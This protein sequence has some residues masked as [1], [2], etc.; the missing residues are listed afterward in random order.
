MN[1]EENKEASGPGRFL[2]MPTM[3]LTIEIVGYASS[4]VTLPDDVAAW[5]IEVSDMAHTVPAALCAS[6]VGDV[7]CDD[8]LAHEGDPVVLQ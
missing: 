3:K 8:R 1:T 7:S 6:I 5:I 4:S 2:A